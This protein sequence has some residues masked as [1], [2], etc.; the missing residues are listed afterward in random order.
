M[1]RVLK[2]IIEDTRMYPG[3]GLWGPMSSSGLFFVFESTQ[4][5]GLQRTRKRVWQGIARCYPMARQW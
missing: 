3:S 1:A 2:N 4:I 5:G